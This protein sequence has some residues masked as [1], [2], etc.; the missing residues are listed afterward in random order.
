MLHCF[1]LFVCLFLFMLVQSYGCYSTNETILKNLGWYLTQQNMKTVP[2]ILHF[3]S[4]PQFCYNTWSSS[5]CTT[6]LMRFSC[7]GY[8]RHCWFRV[9]VLMPTPYMHTCSRRPGTAWW[10]HQL[11]TFSALLAIC[12]GNSPVT[13]EFHAQRPV[14][15]S[16]D[17]FFDLRLNKRLSKQSWGWWFETPSHPL[18]RHCN[19][20]INFYKTTSFSHGWCWLFCFFFVVDMF[21]M[22]HVTIY[23]YENLIAPISINFIDL[24]FGCVYS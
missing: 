24:T 5:K 21:N 10:R 18:W 12:A 15:R 9:T 23:N 20:L 3:I 4:V 13:G 14:T 2:I 17:V 19:G 11:E 7:R 16:F 1:C 22:N 6:R 8:S